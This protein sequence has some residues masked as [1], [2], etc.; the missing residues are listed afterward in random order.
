MYQLPT[1]GGKTAVASMFMEA[2]IAE[3]KRILV[4][5]H[6][7]T[8]VKQMV[9]HASRMTTVGR[10]IGKVEENLD[11]NVLV[12][13]VW[14]LAGEK[15][16]NSIIDTPFDFVIVDEAHRTASSTYETILDAL[17][18]K[19][20]NLKLLGLSATP[21]RKDKKSLSKYYKTLI[22]GESVASLIAQGYLSKFKVFATPVK[23]LQ[24]VKKSGEDYN[25]TEL[26]KYMRQSWMVDAAV[27]SYTTHGE[28]KQM[29]VFCVDKAHAKDVL[30]AYIDAGYKKTA[31]IDGDTPEKEREQILADYETLKTDIIISIETMIEGVDLPDTKVIQLNRPT[32]SLIFYMQMIGR[33]MRKKSDGDFLTII[34][35]AGCT[36]EHGMVDA[37]RTWD[38]D[39]GSQI[40]EREDDKI[41]V[42]KRKNGFMDT[43][44]DDLE[45]EGLELIEMDVADYE[46]YILGDLERIEKFNNDLRKQQESMKE[47]LWNK[48]DEFFKKR[49]M[50]VDS[51]WNNYEREYFC[52]GRQ[53]VVQLEIPREFEANGLMVKFRRVYG[54]EKQGIIEEGKE[55]SKL[56]YEFY[57]KEES[58]KLAKEVSETWHKAEK[59]D[60]KLLDIN[61]AREKANEIKREKLEADIQEVITKYDGKIIPFDRWH[62]TDNL[63][64]HIGYYDRKRAIGIKFLKPTLL[65]NNPIEIIGEDGHMIYGSS[66][67]KIDKIVD[68]FEKT[69]ILETIKML[70]DHEN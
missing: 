16:L 63:F 56:V 26:S 3:N 69:K 38:L 43:D 23:D 17:K 33:G 8:L 30:K 65:K 19:N 49:G 46:D 44:Y 66:S 54:R 11:A 39:N 2:K 18:T 13:S 14:T 28:G 52:K 7:S 57:T 35:N 24:Q 64:S 37:E 59:L 48:M 1:G 61:A 5:A 53:M 22:Q 58:I 31:Y 10:M 68:I 12:A 45:E 32:K 20:E 4:L 55:I 51:K 50:T 47:N 29:L 62:M 36:F 15:R 60:D 21:I 34:D 25:I 70:T 41:T 27:K 9:K 6:R 67:T 40:K 42:V